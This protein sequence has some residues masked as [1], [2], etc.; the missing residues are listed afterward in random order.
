MG[1]RTRRIEPGKMGKTGFLKNVLKNVVCTVKCSCRL[2]N[3][4]EVIRSE[5]KE[6]KWRKKI[7]I[8]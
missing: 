6:K 7:S 4:T 2:K 3:L 1:A 8:T 5:A